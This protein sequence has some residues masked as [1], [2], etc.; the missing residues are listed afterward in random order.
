MSA[1]DRVANHAPVTHGNAISVYFADPEGNGIEVFCDTPWHVAQPQLKGWA[2]TQSPEEVLA[3]VEA[4][5]RDELEFQPMETYRAGKA[6]DFG[7]S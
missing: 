5:F 2:P 1:D 7:E 4:S 6:K 3:H